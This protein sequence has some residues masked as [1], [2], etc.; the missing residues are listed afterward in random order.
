MRKVSPIALVAFI[1]LG[2]GSPQPKLVYVDLNRVLAAEPEMK[3]EAITLPKPP[4]AKGPATLKQEG[5]SA[6]TV[7][8]RTLGRL[9]MA[10]KLIAENRQTSIESLQRLL[11]RIYLAKAED[12]ITKREKDASPSQDAFFDE[13]FASLRAL[14]EAYGEERGPLLAELNIK[15]NGNLTLFDQP[16]PETIGAIDRYNLLRSNELRRQLREI[17]FRYETQAQ[18][19]FGEAQAKIDEEI[20]RLRTQA[21]KERIEAEDRA[22]Q[23]AREQAKVSSAPIEVEIQSLIPPT[24]PAVPARQVTIPGT[25]QLPDAPDNKAR[26]IFGSLEERRHILDEQVKIWVETSGMR[27]SLKPDGADDAT[28]EFLRWRSAHKVGL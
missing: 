18:V 13:A 25:K 26:Q 2:C 8:D 27:R 14:F 11:R 12:E 9:E 28:E 10:K 3:Q 15:A 19:L 5:M 16:V 6:T 23:D 22:L 24:L 1:L 17:A 4:N 21:A 7:S 20:T